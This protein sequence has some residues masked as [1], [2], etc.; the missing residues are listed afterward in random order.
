LREA[1]DR[2]DEGVT[3][4]LDDPTWVDAGRPT[5]G[6]VPPD[7]STEDDFYT[8]HELSLFI[9]ERLA[10]GIDRR[11]NSWSQ[12]DTIAA[13]LIAAH[14]ILLLAIVAGGSLYLDDLRAQAYA[15]NQP[16]WQF[17]AG[18]NGT[19]FAPVPRVLDWVQSRFFPLEHTP[20][21]LVT[22]VVR[23][24]LAIGFWRL[25]RRLFGARPAILLPF[26]VLLFTPALLPATTW[27]RQSITAL[28]CTVAIV[29]ALDAQLRWILY[30]RRIDLLAVAAITAV[31]LGCYEKAAAIPAI[32]LGASLVIFAGGPKR[33]RRATRAAG[34]LRAAFAGVAAS[35]VLVV[36]FLVIYRSGPYDQGTTAHPTIFNILQL[37]WDTATRTTIPLL[38]GGPYHWAY[39]YGEPYAGVALLRTAIWVF[40]LVIVLI[41]AA[42]AVRRAPSRS[43]RALILLLVWSVPSVAIVAIGRYTTLQLALAVA[44]RLWTDLVPAFLIAGALAALPWQVGVLRAEPETSNQAYPE[45]TTGSHRRIDRGAPME[46]TVPVIAGGLAML[47][48]L[49]GSIYSSVTYASNWWNNPTGQWIANVRSSL[50]NAEPFPRILATP[51]PE[52]VMPSWVGTQLPTDAPLLLLLRPDIRFYDGDGDA[53]V[54]N[55]LGVRAPFLRSPLGQSKRASLCAVPIPVGAKK[56]V[57]IRLVKPTLYLPGAQVEVGMLLQET[58]KVEVTVVTPTGQTIAPQRFTDDDLPQGPHTLHFPVPYGKAISSVLVKT[59][60]AKPGC[61]TFARVWVPLT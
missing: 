61:V 25:L 31:G 18:S 29:W 34:S 16:F 35:S 13:A 24:F 58:T 2:K 5:R 45:P 51:L 8:G 20:A 42:L 28:A 54:I 46:I 32:L 47:I 53:R 10:R 43:A 55:P 57:R 1:G 7:G 60:A 33:A 37:G 59:N 49:A 50:Q 41:G 56:P 30:R 15:L 52:S 48:V 17:I 21:V 26:A 40:C 39:A 6:A 14:L 9:P 36:I 19:H 4:R 44:D 3:E 12:V 11:R 27:Y 38:L 22:M 23:L